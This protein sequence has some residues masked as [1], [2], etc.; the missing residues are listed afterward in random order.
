[1]KNKKTNILLIGATIV[2]WILIILRITGYTKPD[3]SIDESVSN[4]AANTNV[5][6]PMDTLELILDY[7]DP[8]LEKKI[9]IKTGNTVTSKISKPSSKLTRTKKGKPI[10]KWP[11]I[12][13]GG[14]IE[15]ENN[16]E[17]LGIFTLDNKKHILPENA[18]ID[19][20]LIL[21][22]EEGSIIVSFN[23]EIKGIPKT[24]TK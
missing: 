8:F 4:V 22:I 10:V 24:V 12:I 6:K 3:I 19:N 23:N 16:G 14:M 2:V 21:S 13:Y 1:M 11:N 20:I 9:S 18:T 7:K 15:S 5:I 17:V